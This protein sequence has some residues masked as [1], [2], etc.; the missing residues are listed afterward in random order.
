MNIIFST[1]RQWNPGDEFILLGCIN[2][3]RESLS[4]QGKDFNPV[5]FN[6]NPQIR[7]ARKN[8]LI[9]MIDNLLGRDFIEKFLDNSVKDRLPMDYADLVV[10]AGSP[11]WRGK[12]LEKLYDSIVHYNIPALFLGIGTSGRFT[13]DENRFT[14]NEMKTLKNAKLIT[15]RDQ[16]TFE[17]LQPLTTHQLPCPA[18]FS[19]TKERKI[20]SVKR[21]GLI[22]G[23][24]D[25]VKNN[26]VSV[27]THRYLVTLYNHI[28]QRYSADYEI[29]FVAHYVDELS[30]FQKDFPGR[31]LRYSYDS[32][33]YLDIFSRYD[34]VIGHR[35]HGIGM[36]ASLGVPGIMI[37]HDQRSQ[38]V[39]GFLASLI[40]VGT[41]L[42]SFDR[43]LREKI[44]NID[45][46]NTRLLEHKALTKQR[47][48]K[49]L[50]DADL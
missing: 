8:D 20:G 47:Y 40:S 22:Y 15:C 23:T 26:N 2:L 5:I 34:L 33:D 12:R 16:D 27:E 9:K 13:F 24:H 31:T 45:R 41:E 25:A 10:F 4:A 44:E 21:I 50:E 1:T 17:S 43:H 28:L 46:H 11:E 42:E 14:K 6:R 49:L 18:L 38:T 36:S 32:R 19:S 7:R 3:L 39:N 30:P 37:A 35:V 48:L 29:E